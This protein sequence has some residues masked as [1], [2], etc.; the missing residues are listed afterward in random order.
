MT[1]SVFASRRQRRIREQL[2]DAVV[3]AMAESRDIELDKRPRSI[4]QFLAIDEVVE[5][6]D[7]VNTL[8][9]TLDRAAFVAE[10]LTEMIDPQTWRDFGGDDGQGHYEG[11]YR[12]DQTA[13]EIEKWKELARG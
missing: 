9:R 8:E 11:D 13:A 1:K 12:A 3:Q 7:R 4:R 5:L 6:L 10:H 2:H